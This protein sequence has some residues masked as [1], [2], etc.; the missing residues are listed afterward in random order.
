MGL[1]RD[2]GPQA[3]SDP[4]EPARVPGCEELH[5]AAAAAGREQS[6]ETAGGFQ[7]GVDDGGAIPHLFAEDAFHVGEVGAA[8]YDGVH[9]P[10]EHIGKAGPHRQAGCLA[11]RLPGLGHG[12]QVGAGPLHHFGCRVP[13]LDRHAVDARAVGGEGGEDADAA[14]AG[15]RSG[16]LGAGLH[17]PD[18]R[19]RRAPAGLVKGRSRG[20]VAG[21]H[22]RL[23][24]TAQEKIEETQEEVA[25]LAQGTG[26]I[27]EMQRVRPVE[28]IMVGIELTGLPQHRQSAFTGIKDRNGGL[29]GQGA[30][31]RAQGGSRRPGPGDPAA[32]WVRRRAPGGRSPGISIRQLPP[33]CTWATV[34]GGASSWRTTPV[35]G[36]EDGMPFLLSLLW[37]RLR[38]NQVWVLAVLATVVTLA[39]R[40]PAPGSSA[41]RCSSASP[42]PCLWPRPWATATAAG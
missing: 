30:P 9:L 39:G 14:V 27:W 2:A 25:D 10:A 41:C 7:A 19:H 32:G 26:A 42:G 17:H 4:F 1:D 16:L 3:G 23:H 21:N 31:P 6:A 38:C 22:H 33:G 36:N 34:A 37:E 15:D 28:K 5:L 12:H 40:P 13:G 24:P 18:H 29:G 11:F 20:G 8:Q 35:G